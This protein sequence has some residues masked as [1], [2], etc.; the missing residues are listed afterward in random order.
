M[1]MVRRVTMLAL[2]VIGGAVLTG[3]DCDID[4]DWEHGGFFYPGPVVYEDVYYDPW[5]P[6][7]W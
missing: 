5:Y 1:A 6:C 2:I 4:V 7:C 3:G